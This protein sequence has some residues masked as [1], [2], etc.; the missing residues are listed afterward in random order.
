MRRL[1]NTRR[2]IQE[3]ALKRDG[4]Y[5]G[6]LAEDYD[7]IGQYV[8]VA[9]AGSS[10]S[11]AY[12][13]RVAAGDFGGGRVIPRGSPVSVAS[14]RGNLE[15]FLGNLPGCR[16]TCL[17]E[18]WAEDNPTTWDHAEPIDA[19]WTIT[20]GLG[21]EYEVEGG[22]GI[23]RHTELTQ[24]EAFIN[25]DPGGALDF[26]A[27][28]IFCDST[29]T[30]PENWFLDFAFTDFGNGMD[31]RVIADGRIRVQHGDIDETFDLETSFQEKHVS[32][33]VTVAADFTTSFWAWF[34]RGGR[35]AEPLIDEVAPNNVPDRE[36]TTIKI[37]TVTDTLGSGLQEWHIGKLFAC[38]EPNSCTLDDYERTASDWTTGSPFGWDRHDETISSKTIGVDGNRAFITSTS[39]SPAT[40]FLIATYRLKDDDFRVRF[41]LEGHARGEMTHGVD[42]GGG[43]RVGGSGHILSGI[44]TDQ[45]IDP[46]IPT[47][48]DI[49]VEVA[50]SGSTSAPGTTPQQMAVDY[51]IDIWDPTFTTN[52]LTA[53]DALVLDASWGTSQVVMDLKWRLESDGTLRVKAW[54]SALTSEPDW[55]LV[56]TIDP[57]T[58]ALVRTVA[59]N[60]DITHVMR[61]QTAELNTTYLDFYE[62]CSP[63]NS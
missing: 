27:C 12:K 58:W 19:D 50:R 34:T 17:F 32:F 37:Q 47:Y 11:S 60:Y 20:A 6:R 24:N 16:G 15:V 49:E 35:P 55:Q 2:A 33:R 22:H 25:I 26:T 40:G 45:T 23:L 51:F 3:E 54:A 43:G 8:L 21:G 46:S 48:V 10:T 18:T 1:V 5:R 14:H 13:A 41:P 52:Y 29:I 42:V 36:I 9:L 53:S 44:V 28:D 56:Y 59:D 57:T 62:M 7:G 30:D 63:A 31:V 61:L 38:G 4:I 39:S